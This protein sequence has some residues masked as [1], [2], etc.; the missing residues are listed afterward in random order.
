MYWILRTSFLND[1]K[2]Y[3]IL[4]FSETKFQV[5]TDITSKCNDMMQSVAKL[6]GGLI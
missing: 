6:G 5:R 4:K 1:E 2:V 3:K